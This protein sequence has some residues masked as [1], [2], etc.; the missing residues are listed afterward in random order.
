MGSPQEID[1]I[2]ANRRE[3]DMIEKVAQSMAPLSILGGTSAVDVLKKLLEGTVLAKQL[4]P[5]AD[6][7]TKANGKTSTARALHIN[8]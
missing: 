2:R 5:V 1:D 6:A 7:V 8:A 3:R 4:E